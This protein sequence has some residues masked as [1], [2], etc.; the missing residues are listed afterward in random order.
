[1]QT[2]GIEVSVATSKGTGGFHLIYDEKGDRTL[3]VLGVAGTITPKNIPEDFLQTRV[4]I[5]GPILGEVDR[6]LIDFLRFSTS[7]K[8]FLDP[9]GLIRTVGPE[10]RIIHQCD[11]DDFAKIIQQ[12][13]FVKPNE[14]ESRTIT[15]EIDP[16][17]ALRRL[18]EMGARV[19]IV[20][21]AERGSLL[22]VDEK[23]YRIPPYPTTALDPT[24][25]GDVYAGSFITHYVR[26]GNLE[27]SSLYASAAASIMVEQVGPGFA[28]TED[29]V[30]KRMNTIRGRVI[31][32][33][34]AQ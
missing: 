26:V 22:L 32:E 13:D 25:A 24:G 21:L 31:T 16:I 15:G 18:R 11:A 1:M 3:D 20:T 6:G 30:K 33:S 19:P 29:E 5:I 2:F 12:V 23:L 34:L 4:L 10:K 28:L 9:Q 17:L 7:A 8:L 27:Q 14:H